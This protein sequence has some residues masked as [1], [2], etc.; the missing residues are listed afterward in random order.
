MA[1]TRQIE[2]FSAACQMQQQSGGAV[3]DPGFLDRLNGRPQN[4]PKRQ[5]RRA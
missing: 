4:C 5:A 1:G 3:S 2:S